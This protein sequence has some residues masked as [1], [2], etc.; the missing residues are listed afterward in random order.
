MQHILTAPLALTAG[1]ERGA[2]I[3]LGMATEYDDATDDDEP[4][5]RDPDA[6]PAAPRHD[7]DSPWSTDS[8]WSETIG[9]PYVSP[10]VAAAKEQVL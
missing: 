10:S 4:D 6:A 7:A 8:P 9:A 5:S 3:N 2:A 1:R